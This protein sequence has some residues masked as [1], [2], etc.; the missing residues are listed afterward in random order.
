MNKSTNNQLNGQRLLKQV[1][2][3]EWVAITKICIKG[4]NRF[5]GN[6]LNLYSTISYLSKL[7]T[8]LLQLQLPQTTFV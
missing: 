7:S 5:L 8:K 4:T 6:L 2:T 3:Q 1:Q